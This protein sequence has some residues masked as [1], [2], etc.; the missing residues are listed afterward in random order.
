MNPRL[1]TDHSRSAHSQ[2][3]FL[4][5]DK[6]RSRAGAKRY[7][8]AQIWIVDSGLGNPCYQL[9]SVVHPVTAAVNVEQFK[10]YVSDTGV[11]TWMCDIDREVASLSKTIGD[12][13]FQRRMMFE[14]G[15]IH[16]DGT[17]WNTTPSSR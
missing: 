8:D 13:K 17:V 1:R 14:Q 3:H 11:L 16:V 12:G 2:D 7:S 4:R 6:S 9:T 10:M 5:I 15:N